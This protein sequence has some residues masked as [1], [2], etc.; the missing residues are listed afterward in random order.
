[1][2]LII[3]A[4]I[5]VRRCGWISSATAKEA[6]SLC[7]KLFVST[8]LFHNIYTADL[9]TIF[10]PFLMALCL[11]G[12]VVEWLI[13]M[14][15]IPRI[16]SA[17]PRRGV[18]IQSFFRTNTVLMG[19]PLATALYGDGNIGPVAVV[20]PFA[21]LLFNMLGVI[22]LETFRGEKPTPVHLLKGIATNPLICAALLGTAM[23]LLQL[24]LPTVIETSV[25]NIAK[26]A[27]PMSLVLMGAS[28]DFRRLKSSLRNLALCTVVR[29][30]IAPTVFVSSALALGF[31]GV[32]LCTVLMVFSTPIA[33]NSY[34]M[35]LQMDGDADLAGGL[36]LTTTAVSCVT[37][38]LWIWLL[39]SFG[40]L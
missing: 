40:L 12:I 35:A 1:M 33:V 7:F 8:L 30:V 28:L 23:S 11:G 29:L 19:I 24:R 22:T 16:E 37:L 14:A 18:M 4:G 34:T 5:L 10:D 15:L 26:A 25:G 2:F 9:R 31:R 3:A 13:G 20:C 21:T 39:K 36:V 38:F 32:A 6:N 27:T 17:N